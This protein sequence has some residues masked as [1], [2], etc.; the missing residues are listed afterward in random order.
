MRERDHLEDP[1]VDG[2]I[3]LRWIFRKWDVGYGLNR[4]GSRYE[5][6]AGN[7]E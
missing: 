6:V 5:Q 2:R 4:A 1:G 3:I 7:C